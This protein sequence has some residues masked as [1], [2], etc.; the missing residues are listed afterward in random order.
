MAHISPASSEPLRGSDLRAALDFVSD[1]ADTIDDAEAFARCGIEQLPWLAA[2]E[3]TTLSLCDLCSHRRH[4]VGLPAGAIGASAR[5]SFDRHFDAHPLVRYHAVDGGPCVRRISDSIPFAAFRETSLY[6]EYYRQVGIDHAVALPVYVGGGWLVSFV[7]NRHGSDF[8]ERE[9]ALL[10]Q[11][12]PAV[13]RLFRRA[14]LLEQMRRSWLCDAGATADA[15]DGA[16]L[17]L[18]PRERDVLRWVAAGKT[19]RDIADIL[20]ISPRTVHKHLEHVY[21]KLGVETRTAAVMRALA[22]AA[23]PGEHLP[24]CRG[25]RSYSH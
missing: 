22:L 7:L 20:A 13:G 9:V 2:S 10:D 14:G 11:A 1:L 4:V 16:S 3:V 6:D 15:S 21:A 18:T 25:A 5:A 24:P 23:T 8:T 12:R 17:P 19:D